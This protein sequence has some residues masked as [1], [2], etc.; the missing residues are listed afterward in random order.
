[1][2]SLFTR[3]TKL[4]NPRRVAEILKQVSIGPDL[5]DEQRDRARNLIAEF[6]DC[7][8]LSVR[9]VLP[10]PGAEHHIHI[11]AGATFP[12]KVPHQRPLTE[13]Q[14]AYLSE[15]TDELFAAGIIEP[16]RPEDVKCASPLTLAQ[17]LH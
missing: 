2:T 8:A 5:S 14:R 16:I 10:I 4:H 6:A 13:A 15:A 17:K 9:E 12:K 1:D 11:P 7:F 3:T